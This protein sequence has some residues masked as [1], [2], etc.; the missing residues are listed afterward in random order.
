MLSRLDKKRVI[1][2]SLGKEMKKRKK[3]KI[4]CTADGKLAL[5]FRALLHEM[6][7]CCTIFQ[8]K[9]VLS[10]LH[11]KV[12]EI[13]VCIARATMMMIIIINNEPLT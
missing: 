7:N 8:V 11:R 2:N 5:A 3:I 4:D 1:D 6:C 9:P 12:H 10:L 13:F